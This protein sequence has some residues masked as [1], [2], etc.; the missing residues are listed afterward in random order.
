MFDGPPNWVLWC[1]ESKLAGNWKKVET[2]VRKE[3]GMCL[4][5]FE[6]QKELPVEQTDIKFPSIPFP[7]T[8]I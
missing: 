8:D 7:L 4:G 2:P 6:F 1:R 5:K 3:K